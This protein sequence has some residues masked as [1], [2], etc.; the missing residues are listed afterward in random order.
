[1]NLVDRIESYWSKRSNDFSDLRI[2]ELN[3]DN[4]GKMK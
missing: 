1:M 4:Y 3:S 2:E